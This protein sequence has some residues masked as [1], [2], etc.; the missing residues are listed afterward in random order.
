MVDPIQEE[1]D[2]LAELQNTANLL[3][4]R[5]NAK[6]NAATLR[7]KIDE[8][9]KARGEA[10]TSIKQ[11][12]VSNNEA[13]RKA[14]KL[15]RCLIVNNDPNKSDLDGTIITVAN[16][17]FGIV[18]KWVPFRGYESGY[19]VPQ[20]ILDYLRSKKFVRAWSTKDPKTGTDIPHRSV[21]PEYSITVL[22]DLTE[23]EFEELKKTQIASGMTP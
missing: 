19:H 13:K 12:G 5:Y 23:E 17:K 4:V 20:C 10:V 9:K 2:E 6:T 8:V 14:M 3:G 11:A 15:V 18:K 1:L 21:A 22:P 7:E 16:A